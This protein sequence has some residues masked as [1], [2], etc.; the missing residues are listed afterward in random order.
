LRKTFLAVLSALALLSAAVPAWGQMPRGGGGTRIFQPGPV[1]TFGFS[2]ARDRA[3]SPAINSYEMWPAW[4]DSFGK[5]YSQPLIISGT[6]SGGT[7]AT[8]IIAVG[9]GTTPQIAVWKNIQARPTGQYQSNSPRWAHPIEGSQPTTSHPSL[10]DINGH[11]IVFVGTEPGSQG[12]SYVDAFDITDILNGTG[13]RGK[14]VLDAADPNATDIVSA[15][16]LMKYQGHLVLVYTDGN[17]GRIGL[18]YG[19]DGLANGQAISTQQVSYLDPGGRTSS[20]PAPV[21]NG[22][23]FAVGVDTGGAPGA[24]YVYRLEDL[25]TVSG[26]GLIWNSSPSWYE[27][28]STHAGIDASF[29][30]N[31]KNS[32]EIYF[33][34][35]RSYIYG[36]DLAADSSLWPQANADVPNSIGYPG[37]FTNRSP[38][39]DG[40]TNTLYLPVG[41]KPG[42]TQSGVIAVSAS[43]GR[44]RWVSQYG[45]AD[46]DTDPG[47]MQIAGINLDGSPDATNA[48]TAPVIMPCT[49]W[50]DALIVEGLGDDQIAFIDSQT[51]FCGYMTYGPS[52]AQNVSPGYAS[53]VTGEISIATDNS[54]GASNGLIAYTTQNGLDVLDFLPTDISIGHLTIADSSGKQLHPDAQGVYTMKAGDSYKIAATV[55]YRQSPSGDP[56]DTSWPLNPPVQGFVNTG[57][58]WSGGTWVSQGTA[59]TMASQPTGGTWYAVKQLTDVSGN[60]IRPEP[61]E[62]M[63]TMA[64]AMDPTVSLPAQ[65]AEQTVAFKFT[66]TPADVSSTNPLLFLAFATNLNFPSVT[67][68][69]LVQRYPEQSGSQGRA[70]NSPSQCGL[71][72][73][74]I[75]VPVKIEAPTLVVTP[76]YASVTVDQTCS[77]TATY[78]PAGQINAV[79]D[80]GQDV[81]TASAWTSLNSS[82]ATVGYSTGEAYA[83]SAGSATITAEYNKVDGTATLNV[84]TP[85]VPNQ[86]G[87]LTFQA[88]SQ[89]GG[90]RRPVN[91]AK[92][93]DWVTA[94]LVPPVQGEI[95]WGYGG[96]YPAPGCGVVTP[97]EAG[98]QPGAQPPPQPKGAVGPVGALSI[99]AAWRLDD[100]SL[101]YPAENPGYSFG[102]PLPPAGTETILMAVSTHTATGRFQELWAEDGTPLFDVI[103][104]EPVGPP[105][106]Y[107]LASAFDY[108]VDYYEVFW[109]EIP[110]PP[111]SNAKPT[112][113]PVYVTPPEYHGSGELGGRLLVNGTGVAATGL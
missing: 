1:S 109:F 7:P 97:P 27:R 63:G 18:M 60:V 17:S 45:L 55:L 65:G 102:H 47:D 13:T 113:Y 69:L 57:G 84:T 3:V 74:K 4:Q 62:Q 20:S 99:M 10:Y 25:F 73:N 28:F 112:Y 15:P 64:Q 14:A 46:A 9:A 50:G 59:T 21:M 8:Y 54:P 67:D 95:G 87:H 61:V 29:C 44:T 105:K 104:Q 23:A 53:G 81:T 86:N 37:D 43:T 56:S 70:G 106:A 85:P 78:Y 76:A 71:V 12:Y 42:L 2:D 33:S 110:P 68:A 36:I 101:T 66:P 90:F 35:S 94:T 58:T 92:W 75:I 80:P 83:Q 82:V 31:P 32:N 24:V 93:T 26:S 39:F 107:T 77:F 22:T 5:S 30:V 41:T 89:Y 52:P 96:S 51:G 79:Q 91:S 88:T 16:L 19:I 11:A 72:K 40:S 49:E 111:G 98:S 48:Q 34:D 38:A 103:T 108:T 100:V 6:T